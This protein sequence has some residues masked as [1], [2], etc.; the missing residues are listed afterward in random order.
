RFPRKQVF[1]D[2][3]IEPGEDYLHRLSAELKSCAALLALIGPQWLTMTTPTGERRIDADGD[4]VRYEISVALSRDI[5]LI[6]VLVDNAAMPTA[7]ELPEEIRA[8]AKRNAQTMDRQHFKTDF[9]KI[10]PAIRR[11][12]RPS[13]EQAAEW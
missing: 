11:A 10:V 3:T 1:L 12:L 5:L 8:L 4:L 9:E 13:Y 7:G 2:S 6:P